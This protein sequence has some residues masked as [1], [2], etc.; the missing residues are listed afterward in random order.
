M[1][2]IFLVDADD[3]ILDFHQSSLQA[4]KASFEQGGNIW[5][6]EYASVFTTLN[7]KL[8]QSLERK[9][10]TREQLLDTRFSLYLQRLGLEMDAEKFNFRYLT[11][12]AENPLFVTG[13]EEF[14]KSLKKIGRVFIVTNG[15][16]RIQNSRFIISKLYS[17]VD[18]VFI[19]QKIGFDKPAKEY[20]AYV[21]ANIPDFEKNRTVWIGDSLSAD[22]QCANESGIT[23]IWFNPLRKNN[24]TKIIPSFTAENFEQ[25]LT[26]L[27]NL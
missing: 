5:K 25:I 20:S 17:Y 23:S 27:G 2:D 9:E 19:S 15:T 21:C 22:I 12:L 16:A 24:K 7:D 8:W 4:V 26:I 11:H 14:L 18:G 10:I 3:T 13:A 6:E 1:K